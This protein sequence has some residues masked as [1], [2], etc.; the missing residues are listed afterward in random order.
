MKTSGH[1]FLRCMKSTAYFFHTLTSLSQSKNLSSPRLLRCPRMRGI[2]CQELQVFSS[3]SKVQLQV[4]QR[5][6]NL[7][8]LTVTSCTR[9]TSVQQCPFLLTS[10]PPLRSFTDWFS[11][12]RLLIQML[13]SSTLLCLTADICFI[14]LFDSVKRSWKKSNKTTHT[15]SGSRHKCCQLLSVHLIL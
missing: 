3:R 10:P 7:K 1:V 14:N 13:Q 9:F 4:N 6:W 5:F 8:S 2:I 15:V 11:G 12:L